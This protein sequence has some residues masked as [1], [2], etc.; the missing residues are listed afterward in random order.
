ML[1]P[2]DLR[3]LYSAFLAPG[4]VL[5]T[6]HSHQAWP[7]CARDGHLEAWDDAAELVDDKW[8]R[9][10]A[11]ADRVRREHVGDEVHLRGL[12]EVSNHCARRCAYCGLASGTRADDAP[13]GRSSAWASSSRW[14]CCSSG[15]ACARTSAA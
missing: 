15:T 4:R 8:E 10:F 7:D 2:L 12:V 3:P 1:D 14:T 11:K 6:G 9:A 13:A 5:L